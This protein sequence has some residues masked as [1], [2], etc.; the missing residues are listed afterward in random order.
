MGLS[1]G[2]VTARAGEPEGGSAAAT[3]FETPTDGRVAFTY[4][5][6]PEVKDCTLLDE[7]AVRDTIGAVMRVDPFAPAG[8]PAPVRLDVRVTQAPGG[9]VRGTFELVHSSGA[10]MGVSQVEDRTCDGAHLKLIA[11]IALLIQPA[12]A[13]GGGSAGERGAA[14]GGDVGRGAAGGDAGSATGG[15]A[16]VGGTGAKTGGAGDSAAGAGQKAA[17]PTPEANALSRPPGSAGGGAGAAGATPPRPGAPEGGSGVCKSRLI[18]YCAPVDIFSVSLALGGVMSLNYSADP[19]PGVWINAELRPIEMI[20]IGAEVRG[21]FPSRVVADMPVDP[22]KPFGTPKEPDVSNLSGMLVPCF[23][24][25]WL[26]LCG[27][28]H[29]GLTIAQTPGG[30]TSLPIM[31]L[32][33]RLGL[34]IPF[35]DRFFVRAQGDVLFNFTNNGLELYDENLRW[36]QNLVSGFLGVGLGVS[37]K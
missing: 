4:V 3:R 10:S 32:G 19:G 22:T 11:S 12:A 1:L 27:V 14:G 26:M 18:G 5:R 33:P 34:E 23:R 6:A 13:K 24:Y 37:F 15:G 31:G 2:V 25:S 17:G 29:L 7:A 16:N 20:S 8:A 9:A 30:R 28:A 36:A 21:L 35:A